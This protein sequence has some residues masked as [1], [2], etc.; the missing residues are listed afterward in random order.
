M[1]L[2]EYVC[3]TCDHTEERIEFGQEIDTPKCCPKCNTILVR[4]FP[5]KTNFK[6]QYD[7]KKDKVGWA[8]DGYNSSQYW[9]GQ[10]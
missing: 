2:Y 7:P 4:K 8:K 3:E 1:P 9:K 10:S 5:S 6:L